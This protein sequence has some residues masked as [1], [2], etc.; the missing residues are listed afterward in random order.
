MLQYVII[1]PLASIAG[2]ICE[3]LKVLCEAAGFNVHFANVWI[4][5][6]NFVSIRCVLSR[7]SKFRVLKTWLQHCAVW[8]A[9]VLWPDE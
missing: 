3:R 4:A 9:R 8:P 6:I 2:I 7:C 1:R 5:G